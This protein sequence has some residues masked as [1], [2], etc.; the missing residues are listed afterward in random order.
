MSDI[1]MYPDEVDKRDEAERS[2]L[3]RE[4]LAEEA[5]LAVTYLER[6]QAAEAMVHMRRVRDALAS[7]VKC[8]AVVPDEESRDPTKLLEALKRGREELRRVIA[9]R[10]DM[11]AMLA[12]AI[13]CLRGIVDFE[14][15]D[16]R[17]EAARVLCEIDKTGT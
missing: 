5:S 17:A 12:A 8:G 13:A 1:P 15:A 16:P 7:L 10:A 3:L 6:G 14:D 9:E 11:Q 4:T 2:R